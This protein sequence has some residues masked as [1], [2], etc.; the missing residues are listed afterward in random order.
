M[1]AV[2]S[3]G[4]LETTENVTREVPA[5]HYLQHC[6]GTPFARTGSCVASQAGRSGRPVGECHDADQAPPVPTA[7]A[8]LLHLENAKA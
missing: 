2:T 6:T 8:R 4:T 3:Y 1:L 7:A 5:P